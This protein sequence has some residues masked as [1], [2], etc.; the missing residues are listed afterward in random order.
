MDISRQVQNQHVY[1]NLIT[2][3]SWKPLPSI[4]FGRSVKHCKAFYGQNQVCPFVLRVFCYYF[5]ISILHYYI[6]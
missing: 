6:F 1:Q 2:L 5:S 4:S 3:V